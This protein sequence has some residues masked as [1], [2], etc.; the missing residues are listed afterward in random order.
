MA[1]DDENSVFAYIRRNA[2]QSEEML[3]VLN[4]TPKSFPGYKLIMPGEGSWRLALDSD[5]ER[6][7]GSSYLE[8]D[9]ACHR[10]QANKVLVKEH[11]AKAAEK[12][13]EQGAVE[14]GRV[15]ERTF[16]ESEHQDHYWELDIKLPPL[17][18]LIYI[19]ENKD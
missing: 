14:A 19:K 5:A 3:C 16:T 15:K 18:G 7:G 2:D 12:Y 11:K 1:D 10:L 13:P 17:S 4:F 8:G 9:A 6:F